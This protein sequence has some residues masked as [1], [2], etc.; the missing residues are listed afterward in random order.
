MQRTHGSRVG[1]GRSDRRIRRGR[2]GTRRRTAWMPLAAALCAGLPGTVP[3]V[4]LEFSDLPREYAIPKTEMA[5]DID[6]RLDDWD[7]QTALV[8]DIA[9]ETQPPEQHFVTV[10]HPFRG[11]QDLSARVML[12]WDDEH[13]YA[14]ARVRDDHLRGMAP[15]TAHHEGPDGWACDGVM[16]CLRS[17]RQPIHRPGPHTTL[18]LRYTVPEGGRGDTVDFR[19]HPDTRWKLT[20][21]SRLASAE[22]EDGY[23][24]EG[25]IPWAELRFKPGPGE[26]LHIGIMVVDVDPDRTLKQLGWY[27]SENAVCRLVADP[28]AIGLLSFARDRVAAGQ[29]PQTVRF[30][31]DAPVS[32]VR[33]DAIRLTGPGGLDRSVPIGQTVPHGRRAEGMLV[34]DDLPALPGVVTVQM[35]ARVA[36]RPA[37]PVSGTFEI[38]PPD[39]E[40]PPDALPPGEI[41]RMPPERTVHHAQADRRR[42]RIRYGHVRDRRGYERWILSHVKTEVDKL[43]TTIE[44]MLG[45]GGHPW[46]S[47]RVLS[48]L[49]L[50]RL[51]GEERYAEWTRMLI[52]SQ[53]RYLEQNRDAQARIH[54]RLN[55][56]IWARY[57][58]WQREPGTRLAPPDA[59]TR[60]AEVWA[61]YADDPPDQM[62]TE[63]GYH[64]RVW[65]RWRDL[66]LIAHF[67][68]ALGRPVDPRITEYLDWHADR[69]LPFAGDSTDNSS[70]YNWL[71]LQYFVEAHVAMGRLDELRANEAF[72]KV[73]ERLRAYFSPGGILPNWGDTSGWMTG[74]MRMDD[75]EFLAR[76]SG[77]G[78]YRHTAHRIAEYAGNFMDADPDQYH[79]PRDRAYGAFAGA[80]L[81]A[82]DAVEPVSPGGASRI[83]FKPRTAP[84]TSEE[85]R[86]RPGLAFG[87]LDQ[88]VPEKALLQ[89]GDDPFGLWA[90]VELLD[91]GGHAGDLPGN[92]AA[93]LDQGSALY[94]GQ[95]Y[96]DKEQADNNVVWIEDLEGVALAGSPAHTEIPAFAEDRAL[97]WLRIRTVR[98][99]GLPLT[100]T[101]DV[102]FVKNGFIVVRD[103]L[104]FQASLKLRAGPA[105][106]TRN[107]APPAGAGAFN[108]WY[109]TLYHTG[110]GVG[111]GVHAFPNPAWDLLIVFAPRAE[112][113]IRVD[114]RYDEN[115][116]RVSPVRL[117][118]SWSGFVREGQSR[119][120]VSVLLPHPPLFDVAPLR[121]RVAIEVDAEHSLLLRAPRCN[122][123]RRPLDGNVVALQLYDGPDALRAEGWNSDA[124]VALVERRPDG[125]LVQALV[126]DGTGLTADGENLDTQARRIQ[127]RAVI[128]PE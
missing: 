21:G 53:L 104:D 15:G 61:S 127:S 27:F 76:L 64:N 39:E 22:T 36:G 109:D 40:A 48:A 123:A 24:L 31:M 33:V 119:T 25:A 124:A 105:W 20:P 9:P 108:A 117:R 80:W 63:W 94:A 98:Y 83:L 111:R 101:R 74:G 93:I 6:G 70:G 19:A 84:L 3:A 8:L 2:R 5:P 11:A 50:Y 58:T 115:P 125:T 41:V 37:Q 23:V 7:P 102:L 57:F 59:E 97:T 62:F 81:H 95:G 1:V 128:A 110:L 47:N 75:L 100:S 122:D 78:R 42:G 99:G 103:R 38:V 55:A 79:G 113:E 32:D 106:H 65:N 28:K 68:Q 82:D 121:E 112:C 67:A 34:F 4:S 35:D 14:A 16:L 107:L 86:T 29:A 126:V 71:G 90:F 54:N 116:W 120:F 26:P 52:E 66:S 17:F 30:Q 96:W 92:L 18:A 91:S 89:S 43:E 88:P 46:A 72:W 87:R 114:D 51:T 56:L 10:H 73:A 69:L 85:R 45:P 13:L 49:A 77:D 44:G 118:Q 60:Y 12:T